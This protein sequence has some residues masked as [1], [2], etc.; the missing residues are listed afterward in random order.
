MLADLAGKPL[1]VRTAERARDSGAENIAV[2]TDHDSIASAVRAAGFN[3]ILT[4]ADHPSGTDRIS[5]AAAVLG[6][7][8]DA[9]VV[10]SQ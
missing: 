5:E 4:R 2:A 7:G 1:V 8:P 9:M 10:N 6:L 3:A